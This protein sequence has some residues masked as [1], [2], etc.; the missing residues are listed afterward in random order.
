ML[1]EG[2]KGLRVERM[3]KKYHHL[4]QWIVVVVGVRVK[5]NAKWWK[6]DATYAPGMGGEFDKVCLSSTANLSPPGFFLGKVRTGVDVC[7]RTYFS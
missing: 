7:S 5:D 1:R 2:V 6:I 3:V 4:P